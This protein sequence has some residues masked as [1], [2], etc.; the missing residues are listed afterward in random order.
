MTVTMKAEYMKQ[1]GKELVHGH[2]SNVPSLQKMSDSKWN[3]TLIF[4]DKT[5]FKSLRVILY[6]SV[7]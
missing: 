1:V 3:H 5:I 6:P 7:I 4:Q 2:A